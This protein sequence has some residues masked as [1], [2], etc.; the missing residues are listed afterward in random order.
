M[1]S[2]VAIVRLG[3]D[4]EGSVKQAIDLIGGID[5]IN[6][7]QRQVVVKPG[8][9]DHRRK[10]YPTV[11]VIDAIVRRFGKAQKI[12]LAE[13]DNYRGTGSERLK[14]YEKLFSRKVVPFNLS[15]DLDVSEMQIAGEKMALSHIL[16]KPNVIV[17]VH[18]PRSF[19][20]GAVLKNLF[21]FVPDRKKLRFHKKLSDV[22]LDIYGAIGGIDLA[23]LDG[24]VIYPSPSSSKGRKADLFLVGRDAVAV[25]TIGAKLAGLDPSAMDII[26]KASKRGF[27]E[28]NIRRI[29]VVG[30]DLS[31]IEEDIIKRK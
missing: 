29:E 26:Q 3:N 13:S 17:S 7:R 4:I 15:E 9:F 11:K 28:G 16:F 10:N 27:G 1:A 21:G 6:V 30:S 24:T 23:V 31:E 20:K 22:I 25:E 5:D 14:V 19:E 2:K 8:I 12:F 18:V